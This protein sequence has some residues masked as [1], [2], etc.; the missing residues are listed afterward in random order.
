M[1]HYNKMIAHCDKCGKIYEIKGRDYK[2]MRDCGIVVLYADCRK[3]SRRVE[4]GEGI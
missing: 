1:Y 3:A 4:I 2:T